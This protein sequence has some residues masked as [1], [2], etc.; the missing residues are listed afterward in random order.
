MQAL[1]L[2]G[3]GWALMG[4]VAWATLK[5]LYPR[6]RSVTYIVLLSVVVTGLM[7]LT[8][9]LSPITDEPKA[10]DSALGGSI[11][12]APYWCFLVLAFTSI[13]FGPIAF[14]RFMLPAKWKW[15]A[16]ALGTIPALIWALGF[17]VYVIW[18]FA[19]ATFDVCLPPGHIEA[20]LGC[21]LMP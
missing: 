9:A 19:S 16:V 17:Y 8:W 4:A 12:T 18:V 13:L 21:R 3:I 7:W 2:L 1:V 6:A 10:W 20:G 14:I 15:L 5:W 11:V